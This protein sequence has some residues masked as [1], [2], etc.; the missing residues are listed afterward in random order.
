MMGDASKDNSEIAP[1]SGCCAFCSFEYYQPYFNVSQSE[2]VGRI[3]RSLTPWRKDFFNDSELPPDLYGPFWI[4]TTI[5]F[6]LSLMG[7]LTTYIKNW[8]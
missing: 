6:L 2:V 5:I 4:L 7:N 8:H 1:P 3:T